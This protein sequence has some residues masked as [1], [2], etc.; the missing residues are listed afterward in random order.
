MPW[1]LHRLEMHHHS[2]CKII[3]HNS[4]ICLHLVDHQDHHNLDNLVN[5]REVL[6]PNNQRML[7]P[8]NNQVSVIDHKINHQVLHNNNQVLRVI[9]N[10]GIIQGIHH[11]LV[12]IQ[13]RFF[14][15]NNFVFNGKY[16]V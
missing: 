3:H 2:Q 7:Q 5:H 11:Q 8:S 6:F 13:V 9:P 4:S 16:L 15:L 10:V 14:L 12:I 1:D